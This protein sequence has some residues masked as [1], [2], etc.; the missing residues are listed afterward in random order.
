MSIDIFLISYITIIMKEIYY[1]PSGQQRPSAIKYV[2]VNK[3][4]A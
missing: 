3:A 4:I 1:S 2:I